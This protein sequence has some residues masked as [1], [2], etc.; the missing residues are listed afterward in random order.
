MTDLNKFPSAIYEEFCTRIAG[1]FV[2]DDRNAAEISVHLRGWK[3]REWS[4]NEGHRKVYLYVQIR[5][6]D[7]LAHELE[8]N[9]RA[10][11][12]ASLVELLQA[13]LCPP[14]KSSHDYHIC[15][16]AANGMNQ[17]TWLC[18]AVDEYLQTAAKSQALQGNAT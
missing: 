10:V 13:Y 17:A 15:S 18:Q 14:A 2:N 1:C 4:R 6:D 8:L 12:P 9:K 5:V 3:H 7:R 11:S 16:A